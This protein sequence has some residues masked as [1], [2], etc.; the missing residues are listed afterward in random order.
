MREFS[1]IAKTDEPA[2][3]AERKQVSVCVCLRVGVYVALIRHTGWC[4]CA[5]SD[6]RLRFH[7]RCVWC[8]SHQSPPRS[9]W[10]SPG[11]H[12]KRSPCVVNSAHVLSALQRT[13][14]E[15]AVTIAEQQ[16]ALAAYKEALEAKTTRRKDS[17][18]VCGSDDAVAFKVR[19][20]TATVV[21]STACSAARRSVSSRV[22]PDPIPF[23]LSQQA[24][25]AKQATFV[26]MFS[27]GST[28]FVPPPNL[29]LR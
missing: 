21:C 28:L 12:S 15:H 19:P 16:S 2:R 17:C 27:R 10:T 7:I 4:S 25:N 11:S 9:H 18:S 14:A 22:N 8:D 13:I 23:Q 26:F 6:R 20:G 5:Q 3:D 1:V 29:R 24:N